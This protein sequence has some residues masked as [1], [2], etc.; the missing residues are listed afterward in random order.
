MMTCFHGESVAL[1]PALIHSLV[2][3]LIDLLAR[4]GVI[5]CLS[6]SSGLNAPKRRGC[7]VCRASNGRGGC[8]DR[9]TRPELS[10]R[11]DNS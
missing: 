3:L 2:L 9:Q 4:P 7:G 6:I 10:S 8:Y 1:R 11:N 5:C